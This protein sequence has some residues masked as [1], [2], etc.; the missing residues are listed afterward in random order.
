MSTAS[1]PA[2]PEKPR[3]R[4]GRVADGYR[5]FGEPNALMVRLCDSDLRRGAWPCARR[6]RLLGELLERLNPIAVPLGD[7]MLPLRSASPE[8]VQQSMRHELAR[9]ALEV[10]GKLQGYAELA[11]LQEEASENIAAR[12]NDVRRRSSPGR[13][14]WTRRR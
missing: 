12:S 6:L 8:Q 13:L 5:V 10:G 7:T 9:I 11:R 1:A 3:K 4:M 2:T 14:G